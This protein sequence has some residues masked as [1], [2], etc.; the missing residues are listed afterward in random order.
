MHSSSERKK[1]REKEKKDSQLLIVRL[2]HSEEV[3]FF[4]ISVLVGMYKS[5]CGCGLKQKL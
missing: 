4:P 5:E 3:I 1:A 2:D